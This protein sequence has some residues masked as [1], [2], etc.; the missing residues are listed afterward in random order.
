M[1]LLQQL[2]PDPSIRPRFLALWP[3]ILTSTWHERPQPF[4][5]SK[6]VVC[7][8]QLP[9]MSSSLHRP[10][11]QGSN[12]FTRIVFVHQAFSLAVLGS[13]LSSVLA[14]GGGLPAVSTGAGLV[15]ATAN[16][17]AM[18]GV[19]KQKSL[20]ALAW[21]RVLLWAA[22][23]REALSVVTLLKTS[24]SSITG[25]VCSLLF[26]EGV[27]ILLAVYWSRAVHG[28]YLASL[29]AA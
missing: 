23:A 7:D 2:L 6:C 4:G 18:V 8:D 21:L 1:G 11:P 15:I 17:V 5:D 10:K 25:F 24:D 28:R 16:A 26:N 14:K 27:L 29:R 12:V 13:G 19:A 9:A 22:V 3:E 20:P